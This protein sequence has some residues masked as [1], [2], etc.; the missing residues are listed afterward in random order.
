MIIV[1]MVMLFLSLLFISLSELLVEE[2][3]TKSILLILCL[4]I[5]RD[6]I[7]LFFAMVRL[8]LSLVSF[9]RV[10]NALTI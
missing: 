7:I 10:I 4:S 9:E 3:A 5:D 2:Q 6:M 8:E 1:S